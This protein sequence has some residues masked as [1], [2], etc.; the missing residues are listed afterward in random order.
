M[1]TALPARLLAIAVAA[2]ALN[3]CAAASPTPQPT[4]DPRKSALVID[5]IHVVW[6]DQEWYP[7]IRRTAAGD[8]AVQVVGTEARVDTTLTSHRVADSMCGAI[9]VSAYDGNVQWIG[10]ETV[11]IHNGTVQLARC[12]ASRA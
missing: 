3:A 9:A 12:N 7:S 2:L 8:L 1:T 10:F 5:N 11:L 4:V 6:S